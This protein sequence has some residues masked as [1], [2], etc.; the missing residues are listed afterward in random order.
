VEIVNK[1]R[2]QKNIF[3]AARSG[4]FR[5]SPYLNTTN[6]DVQ[7]LLEALKEELKEVIRRQF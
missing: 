1:L 5:I 6:D 3:F 4:A 7:I 2:T